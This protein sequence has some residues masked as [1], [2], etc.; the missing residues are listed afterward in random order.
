ME[1]KVKKT[2]ERLCSLKYLDKDILKIGH[3]MGDY[4]RYPRSYKMITPETVANR[5]ILP[6]HVL[7]ENAFE[8]AGLDGVEL[9]LRI[10]SDW[11]SY[12]YKP[13]STSGS[14]SSEIL[15]SKK[16]FVTHDMLEETSKISNFAMEFLTENS[17]YTLLDC[18]V[19]RG[20]YRKKKLYIELKEEKGMFGI[21]DIARTI[22]SA[23]LIATA[24]EEYVS[25]Q[26]FYKRYFL[27]KNIGFIS[28]SFEALEAAEYTLQNTRQ[29]QSPAMHKAINQ[30]Y[31]KYII[32]TTNR[33]ILTPLVQYIEGHPPF[34]KK[35]FRHLL[36]PFIRGIWFD[37][38][39]IK[40]VG[41]I[42]NRINCK[43]APG[44]QLETFVST[45]YSGVVN[46]E[47][48][49]RESGYDRINRNNKN[50]PITNLNCKGLI[51]EICQKT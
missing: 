20:Y 35:M 29:R 33:L 34:D 42:L 25:R 22:K 3:R 15:L 32:A 4:K 19:R 18:F 12:S 48:F 47:R 9:D 43:R 36:E 10:P 45:Y 6:V 8:V 23:S 13:S 11:L 28:F 49:F 2:V 30:H 50:N 17:L 26:P 46:L 24:V 37:P 14:K 38:Y 1:K 51:F 27:R 5:Q 44:N 21:T 40:G 16:I 39:F 41:S 7:L 31:P